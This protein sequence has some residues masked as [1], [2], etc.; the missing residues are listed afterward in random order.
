MQNL[1]CWAILVDHTQVEVLNRLV[2]N[3]LGAQPRDCG[4]TVSKTLLEEV[5]TQKASI[6]NHI[7]DRDGLSA[8]GGH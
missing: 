3:H 1:H 5:R 4:A 7:L 2:L 6:L 8:A